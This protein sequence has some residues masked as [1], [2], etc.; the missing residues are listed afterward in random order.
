MEFELTHRPEEGDRA[1]H[2]LTEALASSPRGARPSQ[3]PL[4]AL[5]LLTWRQLELLVVGRATMNLE[6]LRRM[7]T[8]EAPYSEGH[9][10]VALFWRMMR[11][12]FSELERSLMVRFVWSR[13]RLP[14]REED[15]GCRFKITRLVPRH[16]RGSGGGGSGGDPDAA[17]PHAHTCFFTLDLPEVGRAI[18]E[19]AA[20]TYCPPT[21]SDGEGGHMDRTKT[22]P[23][24]LKLTRARHPPPVYDARRVHAP[25]PLRDHAL[26]RNRHRRQRRQL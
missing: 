26:H 11:D 9:P 19:T 5:R 24:L 23:P 14:L 3:V 8:Y 7:T 6:L 1:D 15:F 17:F 4:A 20:H 16:A 10:S 18:P 13:D 2:F 22:S 21:L 25:L 12:E